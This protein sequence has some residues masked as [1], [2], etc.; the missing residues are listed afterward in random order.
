MAFRVWRGMLA[1][2]VVI[3]AEHRHNGVKEGRTVDRKSKR[4]TSVYAYTICSAKPCVLVD[5]EKAPGIH[6]VRWDGHNQFG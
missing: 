3:L 4:H 2:L 1:F 6:E 5:E